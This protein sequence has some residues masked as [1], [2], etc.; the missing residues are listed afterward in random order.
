MGGRSMGGSD[1]AQQISAW[2]AE[3]FTATSV[4]G[5]TVY[6]LTAR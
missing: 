5:A 6:D 3:N 2:V 4:G 1:A